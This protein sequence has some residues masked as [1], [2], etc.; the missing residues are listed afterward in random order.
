MRRSGCKGRG[1]GRGH[2]IVERR[3]AI[4]DRD[5]GH[6][7]AAHAIARVID[8]I[9]RLLAL[10]D[11]CFTHLDRGV[12]RGVVGGEHGFEIGAGQGVDRDAVAVDGGFEERSLSGLQFEDLL[13]DGAT[14]DELVDHDGLGLADAMG[15]VGGLGFD[16]WVPPRVEVDD[17]VGADEVEAGA[18][19]FEADEKYRGAVGIVPAGL[20]VAAVGG[21]AVEVE[22]VDAEGVEVDEHS[23]EQA[24]P[25]AEDKGAVAFVDDFGE[26]LAEEGAFGAVFDGLGFGEWQQAG[27]AGGLAEAGEG[28]EDLDGGAGEALGFD[29]SEHG[30]S[31]GLF[32]GFVEAALGG[33]EVAVEDL[34]LAGGELGGDFAFEAAEHEGADAAAEV[35]EGAGSGFGVGFALHRAHIAVGEGAAAAE[36]AGHEVFED[37]PQLDEVV[38]EGGAREREAA[39]ALE[40]AGGLGDAAGGVFDVLGFVE[41]EHSPSAGDEAVGVDAE[42]GVAGDDEV[43]VV[44]R[45]AAAGA[46][47]QVH[48][49]G[50]GEAGGF[51]DPVVHDAG[52]R[53]DER[54]GAGAA[55]AVRAVQVEQNRQCLQGLAEAHVVGEHGAEAEVAEGAH[56]AVAAVLVV[57]EGGLQSGGLGAFGYAVEVADLGGE[58]APAVEGGAGVFDFGEQ[59]GGDGGGVGA[60]FLFAAAHFVEFGEGLGVFGEPGFGQAGDAAVGEL[61]VAAAF[62]P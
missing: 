44:W 11:G 22:V 47:V 42:E 26:G 50:G 49:E 52:G 28:F 27:V 53:D 9:H 38:F 5:A 10:L 40:V 25:L 2:G 46:V 41:H 31:V 17:N 15:A 36:E 56:P 21:A 60:E 39:F 62:F 51:G 34:F 8:A 45:V 29:L 57:A 16:L 14:G 12:E 32:D 35:V 13:F 19:G 3:G 7:I 6:A 61:D 58:V 23:L 59:L 48:G 43:D 33:A 24:G 18:A 55:L 37:A 54:G 4:V 20:Q 30:V 1:L